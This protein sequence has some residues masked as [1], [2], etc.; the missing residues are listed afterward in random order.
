MLGKRRQGRELALQLLYKF[1][2]ESSQSDSR[3]TATDDMIQREISM[4]GRTNAGRDLAFLLVRSVIDHI[5]VIDNWIE[6]AAENWT[7]GRLAVIDRNVLRLAV[8]EILF[9]PD[10]PSKVALNEAIDIAK[11]Y[12]SEQ[13]GKFVNGVLDRISS[14]QAGKNRVKQIGDESEES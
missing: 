8:F 6:K 10:V 2:L 3:I 1:D 4:I 13:S 12:G 11:R 9:V 7:I 14:S 5:D